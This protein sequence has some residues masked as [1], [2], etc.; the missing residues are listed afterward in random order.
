MEDAINCG[1]GERGDGAGR[2]GS[3]ETA[4]CSKPGLDSEDGFS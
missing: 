2:L 4:V 1:L 3:E